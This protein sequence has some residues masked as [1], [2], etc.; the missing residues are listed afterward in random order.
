LVR[1]IVHVG[2]AVGVAMINLEGMNEAMGKLM[3]IGEVV[4]NHE[5]MAMLEGDCCGDTDTEADSVPVVVAEA[6]GEC[7]A[8]ANS[9]ANAV[10]DQYLEGWWGQTGAGGQMEGRRGA[11]GVGEGGRG[12]CSGR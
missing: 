7:M 5:G 6:D 8:E 2:E 10:L 4:A 1:D 3:V 12:Q 11:D 9:D